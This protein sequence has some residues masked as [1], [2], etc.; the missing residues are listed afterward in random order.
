MHLG[1]ECC[2]DA[3]P[4]VQGSDTRHRPRQLGC[5]GWVVELNPWKDG[6]PPVAGVQVCTGSAEQGSAVSRKPVYLAQHLAG[7]GAKWVPW[8]KTVGAL[9]VGVAQGPTLEAEAKGKADPKNPRLR[10]SKVR[11]AVHPLAP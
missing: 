9:P 1:Y 6:V 10:E 8:G 4:V 7:S 11:C 5:R 2:Q 3:S